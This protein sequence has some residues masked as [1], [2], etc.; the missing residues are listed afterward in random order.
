[1]TGARAT[2]WRTWG[3]APACGALSLLAAA[4]LAGCAADTARLDYEAAQA[5]R[6]GDLDTALRLYRTILA[7]EPRNAAAHFSTAYLANMRGDR[8]AAVRHYREALDGTLGDPVRMRRL[9]VLALNNLAF[10]LAQGWESL[11]E[12]EA[13]ARRAIE[14]DGERAGTLDTLGF[15]LF[16]QGR[17]LE[18]RPLLERSAALDPDDDATLE[19]LADV[20]LALGDRPAARRALAEALATRPASEARTRQLADRLRS[21]EERDTTPALAGVPEPTPAGGGAR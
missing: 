21:L 14:L 9:T 19:R 11:G 12:A 17:A 13:L 3:R 8:R 10:T 7:R 15:V 6:R 5:R 4:L 2:G 16:R 18:A 20:C 1:M